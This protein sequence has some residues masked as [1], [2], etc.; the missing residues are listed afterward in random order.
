MRTVWVKTDP[1]VEPVTLTEAKLY[2]KITGTGDDTLLNSLIKTA[3]EQIETY[4]GKSLTE[5]TYFAEYD[6]VLNDQFFNLPCHPVKTVSSVKTIDELGATT[7]LTLNSEYYLIGAPFTQIRVAG[8]YSTRRPHLLIEFVAGYGATGLPALPGSL[9]DAVLKRILV[10][11][12]HRGDEGI[13]NNEGFELATPYK[14][15]AWLS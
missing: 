7:T 4:T 1:T 5:K 15:D 12:T 3:R 14:D 2:C 6:K 9:K 11:Y 13:F 10:L 8:I